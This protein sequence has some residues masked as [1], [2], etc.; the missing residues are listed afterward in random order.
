MLSLTYAMKSRM[1]PSNWKSA[2]WP[3]GALVDQ[4]DAQA[5]GQERHL[6]QP[7]AERVEVEVGLLEDVGVGQ[8]RDGRARARRVGARPCSSGARR[9]AALEVLAPDVAVAAHLELERLG[10]RVHDRDA[11]AVQA[12]RDLVAAAAELAA[13]MQLGQHDLDRGQADASG[14][15]ATGMPL[16]LSSTV[17]RPS[18]NRS[19]D[20]VVAAPLEGL[21]DAVVDHL[22]DEVVEAAGPVEPMY[23]PGR[24][25]PPRALENGDVFGVVADS[26]NET[27][28]NRRKIGLH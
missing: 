26:S 18:G 23:M 11:D 5:R 28:L 1:P 10:E 15:T 21:V 4:L 19:D 16:P 2:R 3:L 22:V 9:L 17:T 8:E 14:I 13:G 24:G 6:A 27:R 20:D 12:A 7:L 25:E